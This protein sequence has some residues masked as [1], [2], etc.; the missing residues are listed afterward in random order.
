MGFFDWLLGN[1]TSRFDDRERVFIS[2]GI[3]DKK[4]S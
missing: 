3:E 1:D 4:V 2:F